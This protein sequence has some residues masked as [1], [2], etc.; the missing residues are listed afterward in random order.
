MVINEAFHPL[1]QQNF[2][3][4]FIESSDCC[5]LSLT[6]FWGTVSG[7]VANRRSVST[8]QV[9]ISPLAAGEQTLFLDSGE[10][11]DESMYR[12]SFEK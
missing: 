9:A 5:V 12:N 2:F 7:S 10:N 1:D 4:T 8:A 6:V 11:T 3:F